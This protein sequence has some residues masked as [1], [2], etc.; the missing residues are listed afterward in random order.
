LFS[1]NNPIT[2]I[3]IPLTGMSILVFFFLSVTKKT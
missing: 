1:L 3:I 2:D